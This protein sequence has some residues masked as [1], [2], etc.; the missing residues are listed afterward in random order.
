MNIFKQYGIKEVA[1]VV[2]YSITRIGEEEFYVPVLYFDTLKVTSLDKSVTA[3]PANGGKGNGKI[4]SW[5]FGKDL[6]LK[7]EDA[8][9][10]QMSLNTFMNGRVMAKMS[11]WTSAIAK[12]NVANKYG[13]KHYSTKAFPS[14]ELT[15]AEWEIVYRCAQK[16]GFDPRTGYSED[17]GYNRL[18]GY[19]NHSS[20]Y[21]YDSEGQDAAVDSMVAENRWKLK[22]AYYRRTQ[23]TPHSRNIAPYFDFN[24]NE[25]EGVS[26]VIQDLPRK[27]EFEE[28][29]EVKNLKYGQRW[30]GWRDVTVTFKRKDSDEITRKESLEH[31]DASTDIVIQISYSLEKTPEGFKCVWCYISADNLALRADDPK[32]EEMHPVTPTIDILKSIFT[33]YNKSSEQDGGFNPTFH[34]GNEFFLNHILYYIFPHYLEEAIGDLCWCDMN[35]IT[36]HAMPQEVIDYI[37][38]EITDFSKTGH[39]ENDLY[40]AQAIDRFEKCVVKDRKGLQIDLVEQ[41]QNVKKLYRNDM[42]NFTVF[43]D[44]KTMLPFMMEKFIDEK[45]L[46][47]KCVRVYSDHALTKED[48]LLAVKSYLENQY[49]KEWVQS[50]THSDYIINKVTDQYGNEITMPEKF[51]IVD[52]DNPFIPATGTVKSIRYQEKDNCY[53]VYFSVIKRDYINLKYGTVYYKRSRT[54]DDDVNDITY[55]GTDLSIDVDTFPGEFLIVGETYVREQQTGK[56]RRLQLIINRAAISASTKIQLQAAGNPT[57]FSIDVDVLVPKTDKKSM[58]ELRQYDVEED[59]HEGGFKIVPQ[60]KRHSYTPTMQ[61]REEIVGKNIEIY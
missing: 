2:F 12:L 51:K 5:N 27:Q 28:A 34:I 6:K 29:Q 3:V 8:L 15:E 48:Y 23:K 25:Y 20:K 59:T 24:G 31:H 9:F 58:I 4:L 38:E 11:P 49:D 37:A 26:I 21:M 47:Q 10:S 43:Y 33:G 60:D 61:V 46:S 30:G 45:I 7:L 54:I 16:A 52:G 36:H 42:S 53:L 44:Q 35:G 39:F 19:S 40:E 22:D 13:Q 57:T 50:L 14:P 1:D 56:D 18:D 32:D 41:M 17:I 55:I